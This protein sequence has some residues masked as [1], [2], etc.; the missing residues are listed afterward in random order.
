M[1]VK[2]EY[3]ISTI[4]VLGGFIG[5]IWKFGST[6]M[7]MIVEALMQ[8]MKSQLEAYEKQ[9]AAHE[10]ERK[11][12]L[13]TMK[14]TTCVMQTLLDEAKRHDELSAKAHQAQFEM[15]KQ[16]IAAQKELTDAIKDVT[17]NLRIL[18]VSNGMSKGEQL[19]NGTKS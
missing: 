2:P 8:Q 14:E 10:L 6:I 17:S 1:D 13:A 11:S 12:Y 15:Q 7:K 16:Q 3:I 4:V 18:C 19:V 9:I 5:A